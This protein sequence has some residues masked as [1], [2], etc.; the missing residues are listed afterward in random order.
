LLSFFFGRA[1]GGTI[2]FQ[3]ALVSAMEYSGGVGG[4]CWM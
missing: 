1:S 4:S 3:V 2:T